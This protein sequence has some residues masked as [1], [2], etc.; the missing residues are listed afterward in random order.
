MQSPRLL[1]LLL[2]ML[3]LFHY[4]EYFCAPVFI[5]IERAAFY[6]FYFSVASNSLF[7]L[8]HSPT[9]SILILTLSFC[10]SVHSHIQ[11]FS[12]SPRLPFHCSFSLCVLH[13][14]MSA[15]FLRV[16]CSSA[17]LYLSLFSGR[18]LLPLAKECVCI[19]GF[20]HPVLHFYVFRSL[21]NGISGNLYTWIN[22]FL[23]L[24]CSHLLLLFFFF[25][26]L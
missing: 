26:I 18:F 12:F 22:R 10:L 24:H 15:R 21:Q 20:V 23:L 11:P 16:S 6:L 17:D 2:L 1:L 8:L 4:M 3:L 19:Q 7:F 5:H 25:V 14:A 13:D 9:F